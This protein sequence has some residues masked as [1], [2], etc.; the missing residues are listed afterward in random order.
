MIHKSSYDIFAKERFKLN[1]EGHVDIR[2]DCKGGTLSRLLWIT[3]LLQRND[4]TAIA[5]CLNLDPYSILFVFFREL[6]PII[7]SVY[8]MRAGFGES[9]KIERSDSYYRTKLNDLELS[10]PFYRDV[11]T[12][13]GDVFFSV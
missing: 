13:E 9:L 2:L 10:V 6:L 12:R 1:R 3:V 7:S 5:K 11:S 8:R 4:H